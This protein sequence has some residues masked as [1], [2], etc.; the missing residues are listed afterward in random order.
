MKLNLIKKVLILTG[1]SIS[2]CLTVFSQDI[3]E[4]DGVYYVVSKP[5][6]GDFK[7]YYPDGKIKIEMTLIDGMK[8]GVVKVYFENGE[9][10]EIR[11]FKK[12]IMHGDW[13]TYNENKIKVAEAH[14]IDGKKHG[15]WFIWD[16]GGSLIYEL[17]YT[18]GEKTGIWKNYDNAGKL[19]K[20][21]NYSEEIKQQDHH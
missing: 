21:R 8:D 6:S 2:S 18:M 9:L 12:N 19:I 16:D 5:Y 14:Y 3:K 13:I 1:I 17:E 15:K 10:N 7:S 20:E 11:S 4:V